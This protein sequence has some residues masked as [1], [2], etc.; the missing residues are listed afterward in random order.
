M[1]FLNNLNDYGFRTFWVPFTD[2][3]GFD[4]LGQ[5][6]SY[7]CISVWEFAARSN[8]LRHSAACF[9]I[10]QAG[11]FVF[12][13][14]L[15]ICLGNGLPSEASGSCKLLVCPAACTGKSIQSSRDFAHF[16]YT[17]QAYIYIYVYIFIFALFTQ[18]RIIF[19]F[20]KF[21]IFKNVT[22]TLCG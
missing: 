3:V 22:S 20:R 18:F 9:V 2:S 17:H 6:P 13:L 14:F 21:S 1:Y 11:L 5:Y 8:S 12:L 15:C 7:V 16:G 19:E 10:F 4:V